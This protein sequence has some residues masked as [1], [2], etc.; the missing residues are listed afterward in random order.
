MFLFQRQGLLPRWHSMYFPPE[1]HLGEKAIVEGKYKK[2][3]FV[4]LLEPLL[5]VNYSRLLFLQPAYRQTACCLL[6]F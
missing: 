5:I 3:I 2:P 6:C 4:L 1:R